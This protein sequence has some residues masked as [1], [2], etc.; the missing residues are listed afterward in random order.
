MLKASLSCLIILL[1]CTSCTVV[2]AKKAHSDN[3]I[4]CGVSTHEYNLKMVKSGHITA[5]CNSPEC[6]L[7]I[8]MFAAAWTGVTAIISG[9]IVI[10][11]N[12]VHW[13]EQLGPCDSDELNEQVLETNKPLIQ[14]GGKSIVSKEALEKELVDE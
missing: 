9:S 1:L 4:K 7:S 5:S 2:P 13:L 10:I 11:G 8:G 14:Q 3:D 12:T 6:I